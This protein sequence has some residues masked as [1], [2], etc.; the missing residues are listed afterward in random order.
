MG[1][2][3]AKLVQI[4]EA[5][6]AACGQPVSQMSAPAIRSPLQQALAGQPKQVAVERPAF[7]PGRQA[8]LQFI[9][10]EKITGLCK[11]GQDFVFSH[12]F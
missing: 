8:R 7:R 6:I 4:L 12:R 1:M 9:G 10:C 2:A 3:L 5:G 11:D